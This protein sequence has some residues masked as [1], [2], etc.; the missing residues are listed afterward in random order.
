MS[1]ID[2]DELD[3]AVNNLMGRASNEPGIGDDPQ[4]RTLSISSTLQPNERPTHSKVTTLA[5]GIGSD[6][7]DTQRAIVQDL[8]SL[9]PAGE[10]PHLPVATV[11]I[12]A[13]IPTPSVPAA[14]VAPV[15]PAVPR[16][17]TGRFMDV[18]HPS[19]DMR[20][21][22]SA[23]A[24]V[25]PEREETIE[26]QPATPD[27]ATSVV[28]PEA[29]ATVSEPEESAPAEV[30]ETP[31]ELAA[32][33]VLDGLGEFEEAPLSTPFLPDANDKIEKRPLGSMPQT[34]AFD[35]G[36][37]SEDEEVPAE[38]PEISTTPD[39]PVVDTLPSVT[40]G[41]S[42]VAETP[43]NGEFDKSVTGAEKGED[44]R[45]FDPTSVDVPPTSEEIEVQAIESAEV[46]NNETTEQESVQ[47]I[48]SG[49]TGHLSSGTG[50]YDA[51]VN[52]V[53][54]GDVFDVKNDHHSV[55]HPAKQKSGWMTVVIV[56]LIIIICIGVAAATYYI[57]GMGV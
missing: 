17:A 10:A 35:T 4:P 16:P 21:S 13:S 27:A 51:S 47:A 38:V 46:T 36:A 6:A 2:F 5:Q 54:T 25:V 57:V 18:V 24:L 9:S 53:K 44:Q 29:P 3:K 28:I 55:I 49:D 39:V 11:E 19:S 45:L 52:D 14:P 8:I 56:I 7:T 20:G 22:S 12:P 26:P 50:Q 41:L 15:T 34:S 42:G 30:L 33:D 23:P 1:D 43:I 37:L 32:L 40:E 31:E 48:E